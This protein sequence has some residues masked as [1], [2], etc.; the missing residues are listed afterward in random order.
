M[1]LKNNNNFKK[2]QLL[3]NHVFSPLYFLFFFL[4]EPTSF[5]FGQ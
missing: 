3:H 5:L 2:K 1:F 4:A